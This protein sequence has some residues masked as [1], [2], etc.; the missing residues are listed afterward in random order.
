[1]IVEEHPEE[2]RTYLLAHAL[3]MMYI[4]HVAFIERVLGAR[5]DLC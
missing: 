1:M 4:H 5:S 3:F 2:R